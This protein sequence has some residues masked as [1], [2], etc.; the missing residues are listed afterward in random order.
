MNKKLL[1]NYI[2]DR[3]RYPKNIT[4][5]LKILILCNPCHGFGDVIF[6]MK[7]MKYIVSFYKS[8]V[9]IATTTPDSFF[10]L[11]ASKPDIITLES[12]SN[13]QCRRFSR[14]LLKKDIGLYDLYF[15]APLPAD[16]KIS[17]RDISTLFPSANKDN[18]FFFSEYNDDLNKGF[19]F[20]TGVGEGRDGIFL[21]EIPHSTN[22]YKSLGKYAV[23]YLSE[24]I[25]KAEQCFLNFLE[26]VSTKYKLS[27]FTV[28]SPAWTETISDGKFKKYLSNHYGRLVIHTKEDEFEI[29]T[30]SGKGTLHLRCDIFPVP[31]KNM[32]TLMKYSVDDIL[33]TGDQSITDALSCC[34]N[35]NI[36]YQIAPWKA[37]FAK[38]LAKQLP[39]PFLSKK[40][41]SCGTVKAV[42]YKSDYKKFIKT[43][44]FR[45]R[46]KAKLDAVI[47][48]GIDLTA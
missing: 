16:N 27:V 44:D 13:T 32:L 39:N 21:T 10:K 6:A 14:L 34:A 8:T 11:G 37:D 43:W 41:T 12:G 4:Q 30:G 42:S 23:A 1:E 28:V 33:L 46:G 9:K 2:E 38:H 17:Q 25:E 7:L 5:N 20:N 15:V 26:M 19:D 18:T 22:M 3:K 45:Q 40:S 24:S 31:N 36:F 48:Y 29:T 47:A 35:K